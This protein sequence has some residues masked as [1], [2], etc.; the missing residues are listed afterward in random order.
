REPGMRAFARGPTGIHPRSGARPS[1][2]WPPPANRRRDWSTPRSVD[3]VRFSGSSAGSA[4]S[5]TAVARALV[6]ADQPIRRRF[7]HQAA[8]GAFR[9]PAA[10]ARTDGDIESI[11]LLGH[12]F[13]DGVALL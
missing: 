6:G 13:I 2:R 5:G 7:L 3:R 11:H 4:G 8:A 1:R 10:V 12:F 9:V